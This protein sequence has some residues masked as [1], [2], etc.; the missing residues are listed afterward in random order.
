MNWNFNFQKFFLW[1]LVIFQVFLIFLFENWYQKSTLNDFLSGS[2]IFIS[3][4][5]KQ[6]ERNQKVNRTNNIPKSWSS[7]YFG[8]ELFRA[9]FSSISSIPCE[10]SC[11][12]IITFDTKSIKL[13]LLI[14][15]QTV[16][17]KQ[18]GGWIAGQMEF[19]FSLWVF[20]FHSKLVCFIL[21][22]IFENLISNM[23]PIAL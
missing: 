18:A 14:L 6:S 8:K 22:K 3:T 15:K 23:F 1:V 5:M 12:L 2:F 11:N 21:I 10:K 7:L 16:S 4:P 20:P 13:L 19:W 9:T 17:Y